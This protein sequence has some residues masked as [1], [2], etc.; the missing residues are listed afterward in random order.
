MSIHLTT[1]VQNLSSNCYGKSG[2]H[3]QPSTYWH[4]RIMTQ[5]SKNQ[6]STHSQPT[7][8]FTEEELQDILRY[9]NEHGINPFR[10]VKAIA[11]IRK[12]RIAQAHQSQIQTR[13]TVFQ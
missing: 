10:L 5:N 8:N 3:L 12:Q 13:E 4:T 1:S 9:A 6:P 11:Q 2:I 7:V